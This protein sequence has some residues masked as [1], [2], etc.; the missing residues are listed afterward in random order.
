MHALFLYGTLLDAAALAASSGD[1]RLPWRGIPAVL[2]GAARVTFRG[3]PYPTLIRAPGSVHGLL[4]RP[5]AAALRRLAAYEG[6]TYRLVPVTVVTRH[7]PRRALAWTVPPRM[8][9]ATRPWLPKTP[10]A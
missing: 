7:G 6:P 1:K 9:D 5:T 8:A 4:V 3:T 2:E 10:A